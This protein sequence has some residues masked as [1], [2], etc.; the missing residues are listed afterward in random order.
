MTASERVTF[1]RSLFSDNAVK[2]AALGISAKAGVAISI[3]GS[4]IICELTFTP[5][6]D[7]EP[8]RAVVEQFRTSVLD[9]DLRERIGLETE[10]YRHAVLALAFAPLSR[11]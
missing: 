7:D 10:T 3:A 5:A 11:S 9:Y 1:D 6:L 2:K 8:K 4:D